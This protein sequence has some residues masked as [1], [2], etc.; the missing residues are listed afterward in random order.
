MKP[1]MRRT[2]VLALLGLLAASTPALARD[3]SC[4]DIETRA[5]ASWDGTGRFYLGR[6]IAPVMGHQ[7]AG[8]LER[9]E[10]EAEERTDLLVRELRL[11]RGDV[12]ADLGAGS[13]YFSFRM[14][15]LLP[16]GRVLA[17]D[18]QPE[19]LDIIRQRQRDG[20]P[21]N[22][23]PVLAKPDDPGLA[24][25]SVDLVLLVDVYHELA[26]P[27]EVMLGVKRALRPGGRVA[28]VEYRAE[29]PRVPIKPLHKMTQRQAVRELEAVGLKWQRTVDVLPLQ[30]LM[31]FTLL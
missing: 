21:R 7:A 18:V 22:V 15:R 10:R 17:V 23:E 16:Q 13:G 27:C 8:W 1:A 2:A 29:D 6:E 3:S 20:A 12:V 25:A 30:H 28:L 9:P 31:F 14:A 19:M 11:R 26:R 5:T 4:A 24:P